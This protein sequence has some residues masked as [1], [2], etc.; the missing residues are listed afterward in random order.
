MMN[1]VN[2]ALAPLGIR[3]LTMPCTPQRVWRAIR[4]AGKAA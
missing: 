4:D 3:N 1:A 2:D